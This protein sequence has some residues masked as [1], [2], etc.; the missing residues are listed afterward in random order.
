MTDWTCAWIACE[1]NGAGELSWV[2]IDAI[3]GDGGTDDNVGDGGIDGT[4]G[5]VGNYDNDNNNDT[6]VN[7][8]NVV[9]NGNLGFGGDVTSMMLPVRSVHVCICVCDASESKQQ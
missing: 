3:N 9:E 2:G 4:D 6:D 7:V 1:G 5:I 8:G